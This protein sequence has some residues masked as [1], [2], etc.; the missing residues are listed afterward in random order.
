MCNET[1]AAQLALTLRG[2]VLRLRQAANN[3][4]AALPD[5]AQSCR[6]AAGHL[7]SDAELF[8]K[9]AASN[10]QITSPERRP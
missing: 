10:A 1:P 8:E 6:Y 5:H 2:H 4:A 7:E 3:L 9:I